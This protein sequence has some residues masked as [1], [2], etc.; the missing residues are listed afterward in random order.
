MFHTVRMLYYYYYCTPVRC[1]ISFFFLHR[2]TEVQ[3]LDIGKAKLEVEG[4]LTH[5]LKPAEE[6]GEGEEKRTSNELK[7]QEEE[8]SKRKKERSSISSECYRQSTAAAAAAAAAAICLLHKLNCMRRSLLPS[9][10]QQQKVL[11]VSI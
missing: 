6:G 11:Y 9:F 10:A 3:N 4:K 1:S 2:S 5:S 8:A 7:L